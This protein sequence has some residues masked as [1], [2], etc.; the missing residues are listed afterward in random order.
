VSLVAGLVPPLSSP[1]TVTWASFRECRL[2]ALRNDLNQA[3]VCHALGMR[4]GLVVIAVASIASAPA[5]SAR[6]VD[7]WRALR[8]PFH[9][10]KI[11]A[12][13]DCP[14]SARSRVDL[15]AEGVRMLPGRGP[16]YPNFDSSGELDFYWP[17]LPTQGDFY[18]SGWSGNK[19]LWWVAGTYSGPV[20]IR[21]HRIDGPQFLRFGVGSPPPL[22]LRIRAHKGSPLRKGARDR[23]SYTRV[24]APGCYA[25]QIDGTSFSRV[26]VFKARVIP[27]PNK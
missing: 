8:R 3:V 12:G 5:A 9:L 16:A 2:K 15:G 20:L 11:A 24:R 18:G 25:Y 27:P 4:R 13:A 6:S 26:I 17:P 10:P 14:V 19:V 21:G 1:K 7:V 23:P 22:E